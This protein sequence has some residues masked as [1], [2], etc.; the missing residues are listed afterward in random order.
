MRVPIIESS[1]S[2]RLPFK[3]RMLK[4]EQV[5]LALLLMCPQNSIFHACCLLEV[6]EQQFVMK[7]IEMEK[8]N[9]RY[10]LFSIKIL[11]NDNNS[12]YL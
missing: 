5:F 4:E 7:E 3:R 2:S 11:Y 12:G 10:H 6:S 9:Y 8:D 1:L